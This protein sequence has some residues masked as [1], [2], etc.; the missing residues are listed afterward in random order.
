MLYK[1]CFVNF[2][3]NDK[4]VLQFFYQFKFNI[5]LPIHLHAKFYGDIF[6][7]YQIM[8]FIVKHIRMDKKKL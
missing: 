5:F 2:K 1:C 3:K 8:V 7:E 6:F 4:I